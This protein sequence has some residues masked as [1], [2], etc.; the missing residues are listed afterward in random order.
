MTTD[1][2][3]PRHIAQVLKAHSE[4]H[5]Q[6]FFRAGDSTRYVQARAVRGCLEVSPDMGRTWRRLRESEAVFTDRAG[7]PLF[8]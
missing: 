3:K 5:H 2:Y 1:T 8:T 4:R 6:G 7:Q